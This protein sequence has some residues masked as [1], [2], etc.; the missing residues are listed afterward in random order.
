ME[1]NT[2]QMNEE[3]EIDLRQLFFALLDKIWIIFLSAVGMA[4]IAFIFSKFVIHPLYE[5][6]T[7]I[8]V[9]NRQDIGTTTYSDLQTSTQLTKDYQILVTSRPVT[10]QVISDLDLPYTAEE[11]AE[12]IT[13]TTP[14]DSRILELRISSTN[15]YEAKAV[16]DALAVVSSERISQIMDI[17]KVNTVEAGNLPIKP[18]SP[19]VKRNVLIGGL[20]GIFLSAGVILLIFVLDDTIKTGEDVEKYLGVSVLGTIP[21]ETENNEKAKKNKRKTSFKKG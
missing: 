14:S 1:V 4:L 15:P 3:I 6:T 21:V 9:L 5:S 20:I 8:Y 17:E 13:V 2:N 10:E 18:V 12:M 7:K 16:A 19:N 11:L